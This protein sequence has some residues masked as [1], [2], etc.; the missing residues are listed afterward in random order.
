MNS[1]RRLAYIIAGLTAFWTIF[2]TWYY[3]YGA[4]FYPHGIEVQTPEMLGRS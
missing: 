2:G 3:Y 1:D 4:R